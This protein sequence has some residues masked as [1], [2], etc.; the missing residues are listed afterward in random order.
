ML[1]FL[2]SIFAYSRFSDA[3]DAGQ[4]LFEMLA[5]P[6]IAATQPSP[7]TPAIA[8][9]DSSAGPAPGGTRND[10]YLAAKLSTYLF[11]HK[12]WNESVSAP[13][14]GGLSVCPE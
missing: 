8:L 11:L 7:T 2:F 9:D 5:S 4:P 12:T 13:A 14:T 1:L 6:S 3:P 10:G